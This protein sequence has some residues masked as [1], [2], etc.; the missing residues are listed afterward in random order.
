MNCNLYRILVHSPKKKKHAQNS[1]NAF[2][3]NTLESFIQYK[4]MYKLIITSHQ[5]GHHRNKKYRYLIT[6]SW[7]PKTF[8]RTELSLIIT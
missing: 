5:V 2:L 6:V 4:T 8:L 1:D 7:Y 3:R